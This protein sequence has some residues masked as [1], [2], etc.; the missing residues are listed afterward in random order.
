MPS[1]INI[2]IIFPYVLLWIAIFLSF[3]I[4]H[5]LATLASSLSI[6]FALSVELIEFRALIP[7]TI[8][9]S[10][11]IGTIIFHRRN[12]YLFWTFLVAT[13]VVGFGLGTHEF[14]GFN[15]PLIVDHMILTTGSKPFTLYWNYDKAFTAFFLI[16]L[17]QSV[18]KPSFVS[19]G[20][21][22]KGVIALVATFILTFIFAYLLGLIRWEPK[23]P[24]Y[25]FLWS[26]SNLFITAAAEEA[27]F[28]GIIQSQLYQALSSYTKYAGAVSICTAGIVFGI[29]HFAMG[30]AYILAA[31][32]AGLG[33]GLV[34][35]LTKRLEA[36]ILTHYLL[37]TIHIL[38]FTYPMIESAP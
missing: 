3:F 29:A 36:S 18:Q 16:L 17:Y 8:I 1:N 11:T 14:D 34:F 4:R 33:Y 27:F 31:I 38:F 13:V 12:K 15:N 2:M 28:R 23:F 20:N 24:E 26:L 37:N 7:L 35:H 30:F 25:L 32:V 10:T 9:A 5:K 21:I 19:T 6:I 22:K